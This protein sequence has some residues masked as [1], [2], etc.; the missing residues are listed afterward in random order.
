L[1]IA[2]VI[3]VFLVHPV[4][5]HA[6]VMPVVTAEAFGVS[7]NHSLPGLLGDVGCTHQR[8]HVLV[9]SEVWKMKSSDVARLIT[10]TSMRLAR[11]RSW[12]FMRSSPLR[13]VSACVWRFSLSLTFFWN[14]PVALSVAPSTSEKISITT[15]TSVS[16]KPRSSACLRVMACTPPGRR[17]WTH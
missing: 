15:R 11:L 3:S 8:T 7:E 12:P 16:V 1:A 5:G 17:G 13:A 14:A 6:P 2:S 9:G 10:G 4:P